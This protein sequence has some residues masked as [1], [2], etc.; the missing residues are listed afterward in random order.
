MINGKILYRDREFVD[1][2]EAAINARV[3]ESARKLW[4]ELNHEQY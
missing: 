1:I 4:G 3:L 2:D